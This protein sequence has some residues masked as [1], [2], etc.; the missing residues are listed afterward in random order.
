MTFIPDNITVYFTAGCAISAAMFFIRSKAINYLLYLPFMA[1][2]VWFTWAQTCCLYQIEDRYFEADG[3]AII[4]L[5]VIT[6]LSILTPFH[7]YF[8]AEGRKDSIKE[9]SQHNAVF[10]FFVL[11]MTGVLISAHIGLMW[12]F[13][14]ATTLCASL[15]I[16]HER[17][18][19]A[20]EASWKYIFICSIGIA[21]AFIG[22]L[23]L[24]IAS[25]DA[26]AL[27]LSLENLGN[28]TIRMDPNW[29]KL[30]FLFVVTGFS[31][32]MGIM[33]LFMVDI[34]AKDAAPSPISAM[35]SGGLMNVGF[36]AIFR[37]Y[38]LFAHTRIHNWMNHVLM[39]NA[40]LCILFAAV[41]I[42]RVK[43]YKRLLAYSSMEHGGIALLA[44]SAGGVGY[45]AAVLHLVL[46]SLTKAGLFYQ[47]G[48]V[49]RMFQGKNFDRVG[50]Y[51]RLNP[52]GGS[53][54]LLG[55]ICVIAMPPS[56][57]FISEFMT[58]KA[59]LDKGYTYVFIGVVL[60]LTIVL[61]GMGRSFMKLLFAPL[62]EGVTYNKI[63][64]WESISQL[65]LLGAVIY[66]GVHPPEV[67]TEFIKHSVNTLP[68]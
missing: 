54:L 25:Q 12:A 28:N 17:S 61:Y 21:M 3:I 56:G 7:N 39:I 43:N 27:N 37:F 24:G 44:V 20:L 55:F 47:I 52:W 49:K 14:E 31:V 19:I 22:I 67:I 18:T 38:Q 10:V 64:P 40:V 33:P 29:L 57:L 16:F 66:M 32:K 62:P 2:Q 46:H 35:F 5:S 63:S 60:L 41:Y 9:I 58:F 48:Q 34:D 50:D 1:L 23:F 53:V 30:S 13:L 65:V 4:F 6:L 51:M 26:N 8:Y 42:M 15:L 36:V 11:M 68:Y 45:Y 59:L